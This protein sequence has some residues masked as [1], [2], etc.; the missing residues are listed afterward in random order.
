MVTNQKLCL[1]VCVETTDEWHY[2]ELIL[3]MTLFNIF[4]SV[5][6]SEIE[7]TISKFAADTKLCVQSAEGRD[8]FLRMA[9]RGTRTGLRG[10]PM[11]NKAK[12][13]VLQNART[14][15]RAIPSTN[16]GLAENELRAALRRRT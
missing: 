6:G 12:C 9:S 2:S 8:A 13:K 3:R 14:W 4:V 5:M 11:C 1:D 15:I 16:T 7:C 10:G